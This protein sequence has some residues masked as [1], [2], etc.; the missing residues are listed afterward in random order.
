MRFRMI[1]RR[2]L[3]PFTL[4]DLANFEASEIYRGQFSPSGYQKDLRASGFQLSC[5]PDQ[6]R[7][8][9]LKT[10]V[11]DS[12]LSSHGFQHPVPAVVS[13]HFKSQSKMLLP[14]VKLKI[15]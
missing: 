4:A 5:G 6:K 10:Q 8:V 13:F 2:E 14:K 11:F 1:C 12:H 9:L 15:V 3:G 7:T